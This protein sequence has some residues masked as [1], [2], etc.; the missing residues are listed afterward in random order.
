MISKGKKEYEPSS[1]TVLLKIL[2][3]RVYVKIFI[4]FI[5]KI[6]LVESLLVKACY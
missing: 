2:F 6:F 5:K 4:F 1:L 3:V